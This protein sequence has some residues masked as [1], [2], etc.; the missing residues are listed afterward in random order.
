MSIDTRDQIEIFKYY[1]KYLTMRE[2]SYF[3][4]QI[5]KWKKYCKNIPFEERLATAN[6]AL[7]VCRDPQIFPAI[8]KIPTTL[9]ATNVGSVSCE[10]SFS[11]LRRPKFWNRSRMNEERLSGLRMLLIHRGMITYRPHEISSEMKQNWRK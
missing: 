10:R 9:L 11:A 4:V 8:H 2:S 5:Q 7:A 3:S 6:S 1:M